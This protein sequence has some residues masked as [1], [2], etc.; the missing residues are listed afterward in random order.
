MLSFF[1]NYRKKQQEAK[2]QYRAKVRSHI[3]E[4]ESGKE[5]HLAA[6]YPALLSKDRELAGQAAEAVHA[7]MSRL[8]AAKTIRLAG[9]FRQYTSMEWTIDW[10]R[11]APEDVTAGLDSREVRLSVL[12]LGT[13]HPNG[14]F[15]EQC[16]RALAK[17]EASFPYLALRLNDWVKQV[18]DTAYGLLSDRLDAASADTAVEILP[19]FSQAKK[20]SR[21]TYRQMEAVEEKLRKKILSH[22]Q[23]LSLERL[24][25]RP[26]ATRRFLYRLLLTPE[27][28]PKSEADRLLEREKNGNE[29]AFVIRLILNG[30]SCSDGEVERYLK[31]KSPVVRK[32]ALEIKYARLGS[33][34]EGLETYLLDTAK[35]IRSD[36][37]YI[38]RKHTDFDIVSFYKTKLHTPEE[39]VAILGIGENGSAKDAGV[40]TEYLLS[41][42][43]RLVRYAMKALSSLGAPGLDDIYWNYLQDTDPG[44]SKAAYLAVRRSGLFYGAKRLYRAYENSV[45]V[46]V[47]KYLLYLLVQE[48]SWERLPFLLQLYRPGGCPDNMQTLIR[49]AVCFRSVYARITRKQA[50]EIVRILEQ[51]ESVLP[52]GLKKEIR[53][54]LA[55]ITV[56]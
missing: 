45:C 1:Q 27:V 38:L 4:L 35:G 44:I 30:Y 20:G 11:T 19:F 21:Y 42:R 12:R 26:P 15:R 17:D 49:R 55:H 25:E 53:F 18:R 52:E 14:Y 34:W 5:N 32:K 23:E 31:N 54:D 9:R 29:K 2:A 28:L 3:E 16:M 50:D 48:P 36:A 51:Q 41:G 8:D 22:L 39:A 7:Y 13:F 24:R 37:C 33:A 40:L 47:R 43:A 46:H 6:L 10:T 56:V